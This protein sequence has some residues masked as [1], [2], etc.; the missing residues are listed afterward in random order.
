MAKKEEK[1]KSL[2]RE[3]VGLAGR[4]RRSRTARCT[5]RAGRTFC[6]P[7][8]QAPQPGT[9]DDHGFH[10]TARKPTRSFDPPELTLCPAPPAHVAVQRPGDDL[11]QTEDV[12]ALGGLGVLD[13]F[14]EAADLVAL[15]GQ[16]RLQAG[17]L[18]RVRHAPAPFKA[19]RTAMYSNIPSIERRVVSRTSPAS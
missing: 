7:S 5:W 8:A 14:R 6:S 10:R 18:L 15:L 2:L 1:P 9:G 19:V 4:P 16:L 12:V 3:L 17:D 13:Q 11:A